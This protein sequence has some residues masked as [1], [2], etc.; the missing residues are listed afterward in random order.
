MTPRW[1]KHVQHYGER[2]FTGNG[3][4]YTDEA[5]IAASER[6][7]EQL[8]MEIDLLKNALTRLEVRPLCLVGV[9]TCRSI[10]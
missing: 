10:E 2:A 1:R 9:N 3:N 8:T 5:R 7:I 6:K 4:A